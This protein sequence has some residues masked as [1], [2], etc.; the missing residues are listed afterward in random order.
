MK[1]L[2]S[3]GIALLLAFHVLA[4]NEISSQKIIDAINQKQLVQYDGLTVVGDLDFTELTNKKSKKGYGKLDS[5]EFKSTVEVP[6]IFRN[7]IFK[8]NVIAYKNSMNESRK[9]LN[10]NTNWGTTSSADFNENVVFENCKFEQMSEFKY[11]KFGKIV[12]FQ[13]ST[14]SK[15]AN[16]KYAKFNWESSFANVLFDASSDFKYA[17]FNAISNFEGA[18]FYHNADFKYA[19]FKKPV[20]FNNSKFKSYADFKYADFASGSTLNNT[21]FGS[22]VDFKYSNGKHLR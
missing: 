21:D 10:I 18:K 4:Q 9:I 17:N 8:G 13:G 16:F 22:G 1:T 14:F 11:S 12:N 6:V 7:C 3:F 19:E 2:L 15:Y 5:E 20:T